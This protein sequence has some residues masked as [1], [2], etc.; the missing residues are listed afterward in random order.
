VIPVIYLTARMQG[1]KPRLRCCSGAIAMPISFIG[2]V[3]ADDHAPSI[4]AGLYEN[5]GFDR[6]LIEADGAL[7]AASAGHLRVEKDPR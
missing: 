7:L 2:P 5:H 4:R 6:I 3:A 1:G